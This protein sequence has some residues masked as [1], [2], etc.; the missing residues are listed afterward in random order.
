MYAARLGEERARGLNPFAT[1]ASLG[2]SLA[3]GSDAPV[4]PLGGWESVRAAVH[5]RTGEHAISVEQ[6]FTAHT[7]GG[8]YAAGVD[9]AG[10]IVPGRLAHLAVWETS[11]PGLPG[12]APDVP[13][14]TCRRTI[15]AGRTVWKDR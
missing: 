1:M 5:H 2:V 9:D 11:A 13:F 3:F 14:P 8:W 10:T 15:V 12:L 4:T 6:A 7:V